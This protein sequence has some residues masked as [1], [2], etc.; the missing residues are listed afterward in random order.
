MFTR[1]VVSDILSVALR[2]WG[3][4]VIL[5]DWLCSCSSLSIS[6]RAAAS[7]SK[8]K[9]TLREPL[10]EVRRGLFVDVAWT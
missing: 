7:K 2:L 3:M 5:P 6:D 8:P 9:D 4:G 10:G 1:G